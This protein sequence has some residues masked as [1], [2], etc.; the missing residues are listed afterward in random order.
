MEKKSGKL[1]VRITTTPSA[2][3]KQSVIVLAVPFPKCD[4]A[5]I[6]MLRNPASCGP[7]ES[8]KDAEIV[9]L[10]YAVS[11]RVK[12][13]VANTPLD[14]ANNKLTSFDWYTSEGYLHIVVSCDKTVSNVRVILSKMVVGLTVKA[15]KPIWTSA[16]NA[17][18][19]RP[20]SGNFEWAAAQ[21]QNMC[22]EVLVLIASPMRCDAKKLNDIVSKVSSKIPPAESIKGGKKPE[23]KSNTVEQASLNAPGFMGYFLLNYLQGRDR[24]PLALSDGK[25]IALRSGWSPSKNLKKAIPLYIAK[26]EKMKVNIKGKKTNVLVPVSLYIAILNGGVSVKHLLAW[27]KSNK[28]ASDVSEYIKKQL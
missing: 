3:T 2:R 24:T 9:A 23:N 18:G 21:A 6:R 28:T 5:G 25:I 11:Q 22:K 27:S 7:V 4:S 26:L 10:A 15:L 1:T 19:Q 8:V 14:A 20:S 17:L 12:S 16:M 13:R